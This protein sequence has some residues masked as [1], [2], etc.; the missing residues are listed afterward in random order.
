MGGTDMARLIAAVA[1][2]ALL[3]LGSS[4]ARA[5]YPD[6]PIRIVVPYTPGGTVDVLAR[7]LG[8]RLTAAWGQPVVVENRPG[9]GGNIGADFVAKAPPD[10]YTLFLSTNAPLTI[11]VAAYQ[12]LKYDP[13]RDFVP[14]TVAG[15]NSLML[16]THPSLPAKSIGELIALA[17]AKPGDLSAGTSGLGTTAHL[18]LARFNKLAG[19]D[20]RHIPYRGGVPSLTAAVAGEVPMTF[21]DIVPS[22]PLVREGRLKGLATTGQRR[23]GISPDTPT[24]AEAGLSGF[25]IVATVWFVAPGGTPMDIVHKLN[26]EVLRALNDPEFRGRLLTMGIDPLGKTPEEAAAFLRQE[27]PRWKT[28]VTEAGVKLD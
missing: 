13:L 27:L 22:M 18:S 21:S 12:N 10:G 4:V 8:P 6:R 11:N 3:A 20:I 5:D 16:V 24:M 2:L 28:I 17:K 9:A 23:A 19:V 25:D 26:R 14:I 7:L 15:E 1:G